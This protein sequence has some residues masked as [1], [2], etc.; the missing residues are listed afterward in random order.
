MEL[1]Q[2]ISLVKKN[3]EQAKEALKNRN[4]HNKELQDL[5]KV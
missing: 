4:E 2:S 5:I 1:K 3:L